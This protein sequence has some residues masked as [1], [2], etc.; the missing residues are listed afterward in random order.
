M[1]NPF[2][3]LTTPPSLM[4]E[5]E[6]VDLAEIDLDFAVEDALREEAPTVISPI[7][8]VPANADDLAGMEL[9][10]GLGPAQLAEF[11]PQCQLVR[12]VPGYVLYP[13]GRFNTRLFCV[14]EG[15]LR[16]Y[17]AQG[18]KR[19]RGIVDIGQT[20]GLTHAL[21]MQPTDHALIATEET[22]LLAIE[23]PVLNKFTAR[24][25]VFAQN[26]AALMASY[27]RGDHCL[28]FGERGRRPGAREGYIDPATLLHNQHWLDTMFPRLVDRCRK[29][30]QPLSLVALRVDK[31]DTLDREAGV[32][33]TPFLLEA[34]GRLIVECSRPTDLHVIDNS[35]R[36]LVVL[37]D[38]SLDGARVLA[39]RLREQART[40]AAIDEL[41]LPAVTL[42]MGIVCLAPDETGAALLERAEALI[43]KSVTAGGN[44]LNE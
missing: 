21:G 13:M 5:D 16:L 33:L 41:P 30:G 42:S 43:Q 17:V 36:L 39:N 32:V 10:L 37:P 4:T 1:F 29:S 11:A 15:Q 2:K 3:Q 14:L 24:S 40:L 25:H 27:T 12:V 38:S 22:R 35:R 34:L 18:D 23:L 28:N 19:P 6:V 9:F 31:L 26:Y 20:C 8:S 44:W 7:V